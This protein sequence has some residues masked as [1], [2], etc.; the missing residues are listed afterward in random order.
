LKHAP[1]STQPVLAI[2]LG[3]TTWGILWYPF[4]VIEGAG[5]PSPVATVFA[6]LVATVLGGIVFR[7]AWCEFPANARWLFV[8]GLTAGI[9]NV[10]YLVAIM[11]A[12]VLRIVLL[13]YLAPLWTVPLSHFVLRERLTPSG[14]VVMLLALTGA[15]VMLWRPELGLPSPRNPYEWLG[16]MAGFTFAACNVFVKAAT[17]ASPEAKSLAGSVGVFLVAV[18]VA[19]LFS[20]AIQA[21]P[22]MVARHALLLAVIGATLI[23]TS[24]AL[25]YGLTHLAANRAAVIMLF[26]LVVA[27]VAA[28]YLAGETSRPQ[29]WIGGAMIVAAGLFATLAESRA[30]RAAGIQS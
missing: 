14:Y 21:W 27:A 4:R 19:L 2:L 23:S 26:E 7:H 1:S 15:V 28:H 17:K 20:P 13:F 25:Q 29:E 8:I 5:V 16:L 6:Y 9:T 18:P 24:V 11:Q 3:A 30:H 22:A 12:E 10:S